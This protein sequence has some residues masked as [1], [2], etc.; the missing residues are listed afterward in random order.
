[1]H[2]FSLNCSNLLRLVGLGLGIACAWVPPSAAQIA[3]RGAL[4]QDHDVAPG[5]T[6]QETIE[7]ENTTDEPVEARLKLRDYHFT[8]RGKNEFAKPGAFARSNAPWVEVPR[9]VVT[10]PAHQ[11]EVVEYQVTVPTEAGGSPPEGTYWSIVLIEPILPGSARSTLS[12]SVDGPQVGVRQV[13]R[14]GVQIATHVQASGAS[15]APNMEVVQ[16]DLIQPD[17]TAQL[18]VDMENTGTEMARPN[19]KLEAYDQRGQVALRDAASPKRVYPGTSVRY[20]LPLSE[21]KSGQ[22][23]ALVLVDTGGEQVAGFQ[24]SLNL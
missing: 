12:S 17:S 3:V 14:Y 15:V 1:M 5:E 2:A 13:T 8:H 22:Y 7:I 19:L 16:A 10:I 21:L 24:Y 6:Y 11:T 20:R 9:S 4:A 18:V 23:E